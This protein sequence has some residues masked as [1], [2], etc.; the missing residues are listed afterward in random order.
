MFT[1]QALIG[2]ARRALPFILMAAISPAAM[3]QA[4]NGTTLAGYK[5]LDIC[6]VGDDAGNWRYSGVIA[7]WNEGA[8]DTFGLKITDFVENKTGKNWVKAFDVPITV[9][10]EIPA[11]TTRETAILFPYSVDSAPLA[12]TI[13]NNVSITILNHS[14]QLDKPFGPN[15]KA[16][17]T[18]TMPPPACVQECGCTRTIGYWG[19]HHEEWPTGF[20]PEDGFF[21]SGL[22]WGALLPPTNAG[23]NNN[24]YI[25]LARQ[26]IGAVLNVAKGACVNQGTTDTLALAK[27]YFTAA[28]TP[29]AACPR[30]NSCG[31][32]KDWAAVL[33]DYN[34]GTPSNPNDAVKHCE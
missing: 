25:Q 13:R 34:N 19:T 23:S 22:T 4:Q 32:Q 9:T 6:V 12:G 26:Y 21:N 1:K 24:G 20:S 29:D 5:T 27:A 28:S 14:G 15:P 8:I 33:D 30:A 16:T 7:V 10:G 11:G 31:L 17:Y 3:A 18:G 2:A